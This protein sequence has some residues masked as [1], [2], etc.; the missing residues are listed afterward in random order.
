MPRLSF[1]DFNKAAS[2]DYKPGEPEQMKTNAKKRHRDVIGDEVEKEALNFQQR[3][4]R[5]RI[6]VKHKAKLAMGRRRA[7]K[8]APDSDRLKKRAAKSARNKI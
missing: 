3:R 7:A 6:M 1:K 2:V 5:A 4:H 8:K